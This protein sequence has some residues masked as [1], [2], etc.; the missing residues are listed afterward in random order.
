MTEGLERVKAEIERDFEFCKET[1][2]L[3]VITFYKDYCFGMVMACGF[4]EKIDDWDEINIWWNET[5]SEKF[6][7][8]I[9][10]RS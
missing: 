7:E 9:K 2:G 4:Y 5:M 3:E 1:K 10:N 6:K 8:E